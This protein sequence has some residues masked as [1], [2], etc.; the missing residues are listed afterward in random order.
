LLSKHEE[1][2]DNLISSSFTLLLKQPTMRWK[3]RMS[4]DIHER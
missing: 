1:Q 3:K 4:L 2:A